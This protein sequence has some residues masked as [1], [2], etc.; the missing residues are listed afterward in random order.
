MRRPA[1][2]MTQPGTGVPRSQETAPPQDPSV[3]L[4]LG[5]YGGPKGGGHFLM[6]EVSL[7]SLRPLQKSNPVT[8]DERGFWVK[9]KD[10]SFFFLGFG[11]RVLGFGF[12]V[13]NFGFRVS[14]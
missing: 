4:Y 8:E 13:S 2:R 3:G 10:V 12:R 1:P 6:S 9:K 14:G 11:F 7:Y 5:P